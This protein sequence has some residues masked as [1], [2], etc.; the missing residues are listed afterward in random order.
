MAFS[1]SCSDTTPLYLNLITSSNVYGTTP[2]FNFGYY[3]LPTYTDGMTAVTDALPSAIANATNNL[4]I[5]QPTSSSK[6][7]I[8]FSLMPIL[9]DITLRNLNYKLSAGNPVNWTITK[10]PLG[11]ALTGTYSG[12]TT[13]TP[14]AITVTGLQNSETLNA[15][16]SATVNYANVADNSLNYVTAI[17]GATGTANLSNYAITLA[18]NDTADTNTTN[19]ATITAKALTMSGLL[20]PA[21]KIYNATTAAVVSGTAALQTAEAI[22]TGDSSD[23]KPYSGD[24]VNFTGTAVGT[25]NIKDVGATSVIYSGLGLDNNNYS[26]TL[27]TPASATITAKALTMSGLLVPASKIY[28]ATTAA[29]VSGTAALQ[30]AEAIGTGDSSDGKPYSGDTVNF[31]GTAVGTYNIKDVGATSVI[32]SGL[33]LDNNNYSLTL[34]TPASAT[35]T[36]KALTISGLTAGNKEYDA[37]RTA[38][39]NSTAATG[40]IS[41]DDVTVSAT[42]LFDTKAVGTGK[43]VALTSSY[44]GADKGNYTITDQ[45]STTA[46]ITAK[47]ITISGLTAGNKEYDALRTATVNSSAAT[48]WISGDDVTVSA[49]GLFDTKAVG[50]GKTV[51]L[52]SSYDGADK[53]NYT[54]TDQASTTANITAKGLTVS[55]ATTISPY[56][57]SV[58]TNTLLPPVGLLDSDTVTGVSGLATRTLVG[59]SVDSLSAAT[60]TGL[61][62]YTITYVNGSLQITPA[63]LPPSLPAIISN[64]YIDSMTYLQSLFFLNN[65]DLETGV[66]CN[67]STTYT[68]SAKKCTTSNAGSVL[69]V[70]DGGIN[71]NFIGASLNDD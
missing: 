56:T 39:M 30:T 8:T 43:T 36:A 38:T 5:P 12:S 41:G 9:N 53:G 34:Q 17:S 28:N 44:G 32:Y 51:A 60:G 2:I 26:L 50:T 57:G 47:A 48:G 66:E 3:F 18:R 22:G 10:A 33:G 31:T 29:V 13:I 20:V 15:L 4:S 65:V 62:N 70:I 27:Q 64:R 67:K 35:I 21:S 54:I 19:T 25:Y 16:S 46:N 71:S 37:L 42:G 1:A 14:S 63:A 52:T 45:A 59:T 6:V 40:W 58:Q 61:S 68:T 23:G 11:I 24:T 49:T 69:R 55:G 7:G